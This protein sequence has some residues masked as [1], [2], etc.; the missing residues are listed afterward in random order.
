MG[1]VEQ[2]CGQ[3]VEQF[4]RASDKQHGRMARGG[5]GLPNVSPGPAMPDS[6]MLCGQTTP[7]TALQLFQGWPARRADS[8]QSLSTLLDTPRRTPTIISVGSGVKWQWEV[9]E[10][11]STRVEGCNWPGRTGLW[12][13]NCR[14]AG[15]YRV[16]RSDCNEEKDLL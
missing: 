7:E 10:R 15:V 4:T 9:V 1:G 11:K 2:K 8:L 14:D 12:G 5:H 16:F 6:F 13:N 3:G